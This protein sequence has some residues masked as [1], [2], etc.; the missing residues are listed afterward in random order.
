[1][2]DLKNIFFLTSCQSCQDKVKEKE[3]ESQVM[4]T[5]EEE[6]KDQDEES[7]TS[8]KEYYTDPPSEFECDIMGELADTLC[9]GRT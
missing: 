3:K 7:G 4:M 2:K 9:A 8:D 6:V 5:R 1:M